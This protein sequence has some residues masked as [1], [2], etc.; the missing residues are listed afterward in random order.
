M[1]LNK[2]T[3]VNPMRHVGDAAVSEM[4]S[5][6]KGNKNRSGGMLGPGVPNP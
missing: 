4:L 2:G 3:S 5:G 6:L 1:K